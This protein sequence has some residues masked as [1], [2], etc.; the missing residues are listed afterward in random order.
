M[1]ELLGIIGTLFILIA[2][3]QNNSNCIRLFD[4]IGA[5]FFV[6]Y[7]LQIHAIS[8]WLLNSIIIIINIIKI[9]NQKR[10]KINGRKE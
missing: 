2:F 10:G 4:S 6:I 7:G 9:Y 3:L 8:V 5:L 1:V